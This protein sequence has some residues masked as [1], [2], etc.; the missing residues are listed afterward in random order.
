MCNINLLLFIID[1]RCQ[2]KQE[3]Q[4]RCSFYIWID[5]SHFISRNWESG[6][7]IVAA[8]RKLQSI[9]GDQK[10]I[11]HDNLCTS[12]GPVIRLETERNSTIKYLTKSYTINMFMMAAYPE[13][14]ATFFYN[15]F[16]IYQPT[17]SIKATFLW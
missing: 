16:C 14:C 5:T 6:D 17:R 11:V 4:W 7:N 9:Q 2:V 13:I 10:G 15:Y 1:D 12:F 8:S 3:K